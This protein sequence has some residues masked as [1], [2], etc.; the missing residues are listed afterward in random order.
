MCHQTNYILLRFILHKQLHNNNRF[1]SVKLLFSHRRHINIDWVLDWFVF[2]SHL[3]VVAVINMWPISK[4]WS[5]PSGPL[6]SSL[7]RNPAKRPFACQGVVILDKGHHWTSHPTDISISKFCNTKHYPY[8][9]RIQ[10]KAYWAYAPLKFS[11][12][13]ELGYIYKCAHISVSSYVIII[14]LPLITDFVYHADS[15]W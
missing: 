11:K 10:G 6:V 1:D 3:T 12:I 14:Y 15:A 8:Q 7:L 5:F 9:A 4:F 13:M 2:L